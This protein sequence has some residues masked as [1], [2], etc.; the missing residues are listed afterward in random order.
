[1][2]VEL[3]VSLEVT[4]ADGPE[5]F[6]A[7]LREAALEGISHALKHGHQEGFVHER[8]ETVS[9]DVEAVNFHDAIQYTH[10]PDEG[11]PGVIG[12]DGECSH[13]GHDYEDK[14]DG[15]D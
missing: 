15:T 14:T 9:I 13:C 1:M 2:K 10:C 4:T 7:E 8:S 5:H 12:P 3:L 11:C 6:E